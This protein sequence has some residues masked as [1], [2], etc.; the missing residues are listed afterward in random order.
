MKKPKTTHLVLPERTR[1]KAAMTAAM[2]GQSVSEY[3]A[4][5]ID[6]DAAAAGI[7][8]LVDNEQPGAAGRETKEVK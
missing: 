2:K 7:D 6:A 4:T 3:V 5:L 1:R 8:A